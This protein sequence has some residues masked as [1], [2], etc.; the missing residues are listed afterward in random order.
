V[1]RLPVGRPW[2]DSLQRQGFSLNQTGSWNHPA[3]YPMDIGDFSAELKRPELE[4]DR[5]QSSAEVKITWSYTST[6]PHHFMVL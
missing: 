1:T 2:F 6:P 3:S 4:A 5:S